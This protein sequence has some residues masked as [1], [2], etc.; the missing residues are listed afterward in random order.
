MK[1]ILFLFAAILFTYTTNYA[2][3]GI[4][5]TDPKA[6]LDINGDLIIKNVPEL[7][8]TF[9]KIL[10]L[11][12]ST[13]RVEYVD[14]SN[15]NFSKSYLKG[16]GGV[17]FTVLGATLIS[18]WNQISFPNIEFDENTDYNTT[19]QYFEAPVDGIY[20]VYVYVKMTSL[21]NV[22]DLGVG[23]FKNSSGVNTLIADESYESL[24]VSVLGIGITS[25]PTRSTETLVK[26]NAGDRIYFG[27]KSNNLIVF[28]NAEAQFSIFQLK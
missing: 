19:N 7:T 21:V 20:N 14:A 23:I 9:D 2:Q 25:P 17:G 26:L 16:V 12:G 3:V 1:K 5:E 11:N 24:S 10:T 13:N 4:N 28:N 22:S 15:V 6:T 18:G 27:I 8:D